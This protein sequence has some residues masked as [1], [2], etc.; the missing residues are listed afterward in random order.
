MKITIR[1]ASLHDSKL[2]GSMHLIIESPVIEVIKPLILQTYNRVQ[3]PSQNAATG[4]HR[5]SELGPQES[6]KSTQIQLKSPKVDEIHRKP[7]LANEREA[8][9]NVTS[10]IQSERTEEVLEVNSV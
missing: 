5:M 3:T 2:P 1:A 8:R 7:V 4:C 10:D 6:M 9:T